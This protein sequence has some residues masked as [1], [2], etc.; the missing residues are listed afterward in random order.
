VRCASE[1]VLR[2]RDDGFCCV[3]IIFG[4]IFDYTSRLRWLRVQIRVV[5]T[6]LAAPSRE[7]L[8][9][10]MECGFGSVNEE[11]GSANREL[12]ILKWQFGACLSLL[13]GAGKDFAS[14]NRRIAKSVDICY[15]LLAGLRLLVVLE[16]SLVVDVCYLASSEV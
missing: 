13:E 5:L 8:S 2:V 9:T 7:H 11:L 3:S 16:Y 10:R 6:G 4:D 14:H 12:G 1:L 15:L